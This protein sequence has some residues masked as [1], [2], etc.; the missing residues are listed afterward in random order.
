M[1]AWVERYRS[2]QYIMV[3]YVNSDVQYKMYKG[4]E[5][6]F[7]NLG[8]IDINSSKEGS[9]FL[10]VMAWEAGALAVYCL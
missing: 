5:T 2:G 10:F 9:Q 7:Q 6:N 1:V 4:F 8:W 3:F